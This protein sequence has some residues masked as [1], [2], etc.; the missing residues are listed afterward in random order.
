MFVVNEKKRWTPWS[1][2]VH[3]KACKSSNFF[4]WVYLSGKAWALKPA[5]LG[6]LEAAGQTNKTE[7]TAQQERVQRQLGIFNVVTFPNDPCA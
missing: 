6:S 7:T 4:I 5:W 2:S 3:K 1:T